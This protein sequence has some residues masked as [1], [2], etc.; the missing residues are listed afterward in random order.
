MA[1]KAAKKT[2]KKK[3]TKKAAKKKA[4]RGKQYGGANPP[5]RQKA[6]LEPPAE[7]EPLIVSVIWFARWNGVRE[8]TVRKWID[9][10]MPVIARG[11]SG[12][13]AKIDAAAAQKW[14]THRHAPEGSTQKSERE[15]L[16]RIQAKKQ[17]LEVRRMEGELV[18]AE[19]VEQMLGELVAYLGPALD[20]IAGR[21]ARP[22]ANLSE[23]GAV[24][25]K[26]LDAIREVR[27]RI[28]RQLERAGY[29]AEYRE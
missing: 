29:P 27:D 18:E 4:V 5:K 21:L 10:G 1:K 23:P 12:V 19:E 9:E 15:R 8:S 11:T 22:L 17:E 26:M 25:R 20:G 3:R 6:P 24:R 2:A 7:G 28:A 13:P 16:Y 14:L